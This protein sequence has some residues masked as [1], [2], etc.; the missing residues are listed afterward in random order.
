MISLIEIFRVHLSRLGPACC[1]RHINNYIIYTCK[2]HYVKFSHENH[3]KV[4][5]IKKYEII[6]SG[7]SEGLKNNFENHKNILDLVVFE[8]TINFL[9]K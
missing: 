7:K 5:S 2:L 9:K 1:S 8:Y 6:N 4:E 3:E